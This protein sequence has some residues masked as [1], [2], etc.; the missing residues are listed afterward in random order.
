MMISAAHCPWTVL[1][2]RFFLYYTDIISR[3]FREEYL[4]M[5]IS[6]DSGF[7]AH[8]YTTFYELLYYY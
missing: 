3:S 4:S 2:I 6:V 8:I 1:F 5:S 7:Q